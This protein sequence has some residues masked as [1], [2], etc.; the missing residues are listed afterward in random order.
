MIQYRAFLFSQATWT[1]GEKKHRR[2]VCRFLLAHT[3]GV[4]HDAVR[5]ILQ[6]FECLLKTIQQSDMIG[7]VIYSRLNADHLHVQYAPYVYQIS[8]V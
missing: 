6:H 4:S 5:S 3:N 7:F 1:E 2:S 8:L